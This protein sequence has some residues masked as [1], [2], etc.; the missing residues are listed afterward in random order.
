M[1]QGRLKAALLSG[2]WPAFMVLSLVACHES[3]RAPGGAVR[4]PV[5][6]PAEPPEGA[7]DCPAYATSQSVFMAASNQTWSQAAELTNRVFPQATGGSAV[8]PRNNFIDDYIVGKIETDGIPHSA[9]CT[10]EEFV[11]RVYLDLSGRIPPTDQV[12]AFLAAPSPTKRADLIDALLGTEPYVDRFTMWFGD[13]LENAYS[14]PNN[15][16]LFSGRT[17]YFYKIRDF[18][19]TNRPYNQFVTE[20]LSSSGY[21]WDPTNGPVNFLARAW[22]NMVNRLDVID[23]IAVEAGRDFLGLPILCISCHNGAGHLERVNLFLSRQRRADFWGLGAFYGQLNYVRR[24]ESPNIFSYT[25]EFDTYAS[26]TG[27][28]RNGPGSGGGNRPARLPPGVTPPSYFFTG[29]DPQEG[30]NFRAAFARLLIADRQFARATVN[31]LWKEMLGMG[32]VDPPDA[33][34]LARL[35]PANPPPDPWTIQATHPDLLERLADEFIARNYDIQAMIRLIANSTAY[36]LS[37]EFPGT[38]DASYAFYF[39]RHFAK[40]MTAEQL[41]DSIFLATNVG[42]T[43]ATRDIGNVSWTMKLPDPTE[44]TGGGANGTVRDFLNTFL[45]GTRDERKREPGGSILQSMAL[46]NNPLVVNRIRA[47]GGGLVQ[48]LLADASLTD[49][50]IVDRLFLTTLSRYPDAQERTQ[51]LDMLS[52]GRALGTENLNLALFNK[53]DFLFY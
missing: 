21:S 49:G 45:R 25:F 5:I 6:T 53:L 19:S 39:A 12:T 11:R 20:L 9:V 28:N 22:E 51:A 10:D 15:P 36:Q 8:L 43:L 24:E 13:L 23:N 34:D 4:A 47:T 46:L 33:F 44:P 29:G 16:L 3:P 38:F 42:E 35:D 52:R 18:V 50:D 1:A 27:Y 31:Y 17:P 30:E 14:S 7:L 41:V 37:A 32:I 48:T 26:Q 2:R 40:R